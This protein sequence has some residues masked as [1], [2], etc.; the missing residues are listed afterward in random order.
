MCGSFLT[1]RDD[2]VYLIH[3][4]AK[5]Y[6]SDDKVSAAV[7]PYG[8]SAIHHRIFR[9]SL[10]SLSAKLRRNIYS[11]NNPGATI[12]E[13]V[14]LQPQPDPLSNMQYSCIYWLD[15]FIN[16]RSLERPES[17]DDQISDFF[18]KHLLHWLESLGLIGEL[19]HGILSLRKLASC[20]SQHQAIYR[21]AER[22]ASTN[23][24]IIQKAPLQAYSAALVFCPRKSLS[25]R[26]YWDQRLDCIKQAYIM[27]ESWDPCIQVLEGHQSSVHTVAFSPDGQTVASAS[28]DK[29]IRLWDAASG[30]A[31]QVLEGHQGS[32]YAVAFSPD[33][34]TVASASKDKT[35]RLWDAASGAEKHKHHLDI[36][37]TTLSFPDNSCLNTDH[38]SLSLNHQACNL[39]IKQS[40]NEIFI[41]KKWVTRSGQ[42]LI[43]LPPDFR[44]TSAATSS[45][46]VVLGHRSGGL[47]FLWLN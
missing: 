10:Q 28:K 33:G 22:F 30:A 19:R 18:K 9:E 37:V 42:R 34:Q 29:T 44:A 2:H 8:P 14:T 27:Q 24:V 4:S 41:H 11:I 38:G 12:S 26:L 13:I 6:L 36:G 20:Q 43:W 17:A 46:K 40:G 47:T 16:S 1:I 32:V 39:S 5:D 3:Q 31:K 7:F 35:I 45:N 25:K 23:A 15:H 21:E